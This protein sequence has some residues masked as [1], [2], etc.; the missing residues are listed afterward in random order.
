MITKS[1]LKSYRRL[2][3][4][5]L[6]LRAQIYT[7]ERLA[8]DVRAVNYDRIVV[9][10]PYNGSCVEFSVER[11]SELVARYNERIAE[12]ASLQARIEDEVARLQSE[13]DRRL[14]RLRYFEGLSCE[15]CAQRLHMSIQTFHRWHSRILCELR[16]DEML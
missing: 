14:I 16:D 5:I 12:L 10:T 11:I 1:E 2:H 3:E 9:Q 13:S 4:Q 6:G 15:A 7:L 8:G